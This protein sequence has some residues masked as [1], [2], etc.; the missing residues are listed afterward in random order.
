[1]TDRVE[2]AQHYYS[3][4]EQTFAATKLN[5]PMPICTATNLFDREA[6]ERFSK[7]VSDDDFDFSQKD[8]VQHLTHIT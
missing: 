1:L 2:T 7:R 8:I 5:E 6:E 4:L 3:L